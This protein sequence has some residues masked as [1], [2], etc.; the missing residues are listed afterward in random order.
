LNPTASGALQ[1]QGSFDVSADNCG[2]VVDSNASDALQF[3]GG[4]GTL[5]AGYVSVVGGDGGQLGDSSPAPI[6]GAA[7]VINPFPSLS[8]PNPLTDCTTGPSGNTNT[9]TTL[10]SSSTYKTV[11]NITCFPNAVS[12][13]GTV[14]LPSGVVVFEN[15]VTLGGTVNSGTTGSN[16]GTTIDVSGGSFDVSTGTTLNLTAPTTAPTSS[17]PSGIALLQPASNT[18]VVK[19]QDGNSSGTFTGIVYA[20]GAQLFL[21]DSGGDHSG[22]T[23]AYKT[24]LIVNTF[25]DKTATL[26]INSYTT[27]FGSSSPLTAVALVE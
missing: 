26:V 18:N 1:L 11:N 23:V 22:G 19:L 27:S 9:A 16:P 5:T 8:G 4:A 13:S 24:D 2:V 15:G 14:N 3:T 12:M 25:Y 20:P 6:K 7:P 17:V 21:N 10:N